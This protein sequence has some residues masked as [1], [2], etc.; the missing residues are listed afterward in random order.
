MWCN[1][2]A[3]SSRRASQYI[4]RRGQRM[5][6]T[7]K[8]NQSL[9]LCSFSTESDDNK[10]GEDAIYEELFGSSMGSDT[11]PP[12]P[13]PRRSRQ[14]KS[15]SEQETPKLQL[16]DIPKPLWS[17]SLEISDERWATKME[18]NDIPDWSPDFVSRVSKERVKL[19][20]GAFLL[21]S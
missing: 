5:A 10:A 18:F 3:S 21:L 20:P 7:A 8:R 11:L 13:S 9:G 12:P 19:L 1:L 16:S 14:E 15:A 17:D 2:L 6:V 4:G